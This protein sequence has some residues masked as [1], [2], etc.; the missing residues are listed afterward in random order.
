M[1]LLWILFC[2]FV[3]ITLAINLGAIH[4]IRYLLKIYEKGRLRNLFL[5]DYDKQHKQQSPVTGL[6]DIPSMPQ[7]LPTPSSSSSLLFLGQTTI[8]IIIWISLA[9]IFAGIIYLNLGHSKT[10]EF[11]TAYAIEKSLSIDNIFVFWLIF[12]LFGI[13][14]NYQQKVLVTGMFSVF[15]MRVLFILVGISLLQTFH[16]MIYF[17]AS[18][19]LFTGSR[20]MLKKRIKDQKEE[21][22]EIAIEKTIA[23]GIIKKFIPVSLV[24]N[25]NKFFTKIDGVLYATPM[26]VTM[27]IIEIA[28]LVFA[29]DSVSAVLTITTDPFILITSNIFAVLGLRSLYFLLAGTVENF[30]YLKPVLALILFFIGSKALLSQFIEIPIVISL[31]VVVAIIIT[32]IIISFIKIRQHGHR[33]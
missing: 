29:V 27:V 14:S 10:L 5:D 28:D 26:L 18:L 11:V 15:T 30:Y 21:N 22:K 20:M 8:W 25:N 17:V 3:G 32:A 7:Q 2:L 4:K 33:V 6:P 31:A 12:S 16:W 13:P 1:L 24:L 23:I 19:L 9:G